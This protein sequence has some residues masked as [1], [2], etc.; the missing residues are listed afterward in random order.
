[1]KQA[2]RLSRRERNVGFPVHLKYLKTFINVMKQKNKCSKNVYVPY[3]LLK[4]L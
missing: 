4:M 1:M 2:N 3:D